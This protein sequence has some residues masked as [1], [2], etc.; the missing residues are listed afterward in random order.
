MLEESLVP[1]IQSALKDLRYGYVQLIVHDGVLVRVE[2]IERIRLPS[3]F[4]EAGM[5]DRKSGS[6]LTLFEPTDPSK[7]GKPH[8]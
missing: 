3:V 6:P 4:K 7:G 2:R 8:P 1:V 5:A